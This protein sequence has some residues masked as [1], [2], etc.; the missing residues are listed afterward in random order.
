[1]ILFIV[2]V[3]MSDEPKTILK[4]W[5]EVSYTSFNVIL[6]RVA[7]KHIFDVVEEVT[8]SIEVL[9]VGRAIYLAQ[10]L[11][12]LHYDIHHDPRAL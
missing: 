3:E 4:F 9:N 8:D 6:D 1:M 5:F 7:C 11:I 12:Q 10:H 2:D